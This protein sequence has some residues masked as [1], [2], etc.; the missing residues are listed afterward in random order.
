MNRIIIP[1]IISF[2]SGISTVLGCVF[3]Y[4]KIKD[5]NK[6]K[7][8]VFVMAL[9]MTVMIT[10]SIIELIP[11]SMTVLI[12]E[13]G[14]IIF[15]LFTILILFLV[16]II[17]KGVFD[18]KIKISKNHL[19]F[20]GITNMIILT[21]HNIPEGIATFI[22]SYNNFKIGIHLGISILLHNIPEGV[23]IA[24]PIYYGTGSK[25]KAIM[26]T[27]IAGLAEP[28]GGLLFFILFKKYLNI[29]NFNI[30]LLIVGLIMIEVSIEEIY[31]AIEKYNQKKYT[32]AGIVTGIIITIINLL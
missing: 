12:K 32:I 8:I 10:I 3:L 1:L 21:I 19:L 15:V 29:V 22:S 13:K 20:L 27:L 31:P 25:R 30:I 9:S 24:F 28:I 14:S 16:K 23:S 11:K 4:I 18:N 7:I 17:K 6:D 2:I 5:S 26:S